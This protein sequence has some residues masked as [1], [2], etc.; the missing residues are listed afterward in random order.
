MDFLAAF[1][2]ELAGATNICS[3]KKD[4]LVLE[5]PKNVCFAVEEGVVISAGRFAIKV[6][7]FRQL[8]LWLN[9]DVIENFKHYFRKH[10][11]H[12]FVPHVGIHAVY[13]AEIKI[14]N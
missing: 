9:I 14:M 1:E 2:R 5:E 12:F 13:T 4:R 8:K 11:P 10:V 6:F 3:S 7:A